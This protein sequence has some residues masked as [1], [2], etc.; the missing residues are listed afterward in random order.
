MK[1]FSR[2]GL[3][4]TVTVSV[5]AIVML[6]LGVTAIVTAMTISKR[7][8]ADAIAGQDRSLRIAS[9]IV[10]QTIPGAKITYDAAGNVE[11]IT[12][13]D[14]PKTFENHDMIDTIGR[15]SGETA[16]IFAWDPETK[17]FWRKTTNIVKP[18]GKRAVGTQLGQKGAVY[19]VITK[20]KTYRGE[21]VILGLS[22][23]TIYQPI[24]SASGDVTG[25][26]YAGVKASEI[27]AISSE[28]LTMVAFTAVGA[29]LAAAAL[30][31]ALSRHILGGIERLTASAR[32]MTEGN[33]DVS[34]PN[35]DMANEIG[36]L[37]R[38]IDVFRQNAHTHRE[39]EEEAS[40]LRELAQN[41]RQQNETLRNFEAAGIKSSVEILGRGISRL[42]EGDL[43]IHLDTPFHGELDALRRDF[44][45]A[46]SKLNS[47]LSNISADT[48]SIDASAR[49][50]RAASNN[51][52]ER[53]E[54]QAASLE[55]TSAALDEITVTVRNASSKANEAAKLVSTTKGNSEA[56]GEVVADAISAMGRIETAST[57]ISSI[58]NVID[59][60]AFQTNLLAL[61][62]GVEA[63]RA[64][65]A[66]KG[67]AV[68]AQEVR[69]L[70]QRSAAAAKDIKHLIEK[71]GVE[72]NAGVNLV[73]K[74]GD[75]LRGIAGQVSSI[76]DYIATI[77]SSAGEQSTGLGEINTAVNRMDQMTQQNAAMVEETAALTHKLAED[78]RNLAEA[79][80]GFRLAGTVHSAAA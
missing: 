64:G 6:S 47:T 11:R 12:M 56:S 50:M 7:I 21:A 9:Q 63:A 44:N 17:D 58:I 23:Y 62:A 52:A 2:F 66:G 37:S 69:E 8:Q 71:S 10:E 31:Y 42:A 70:A 26:L 33:L 34:I 68:V 43:T 74:A 57:E 28:I 19:P 77:A 22:Y 20:G 38:A 45:N 54:Q 18:D 24:F 61:N 27:N 13:K 1:L 16:T 55:Q 14:V 30:T 3:V 67:F 4:P 48:H 72:V 73:R 60:I 29:L 25:I 65:E 36:E 76:N 46:V 41:E 15:I 80:G 51:L 79:I 78:A 53:T 59:E 39:A 5:I 35:R 32:T 49:E 40:R 75:A